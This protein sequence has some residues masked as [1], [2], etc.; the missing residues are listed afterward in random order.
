MRAL[1]II[2]ACT[3]FLLAG[4]MAARADVITTFTLSNVVF[5]DGGTASG[6]FTLDVTTGTVSDANI[7]TTDTS[8]FLGQ[9]YTSQF[10]TG[11]DFSVSFANP[12]AELFLVVS[13]PLSLMLPS[14]LVFVQETI[15]HPTRSRGT[16][17]GTLIPVPGPIAGAGLP[18]LIFASAGLLGRWRRRLRSAFRLSTPLTA[19]PPTN[20][21][22]Y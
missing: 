15:L 10:A 9:R 17:S 13:V 2:A 20:H 22:P 11:G 18:G 14:P 3:L 8:T 12:P 19:A 6:S 4:A 5:N 7:I 16:D 1:S 21:S